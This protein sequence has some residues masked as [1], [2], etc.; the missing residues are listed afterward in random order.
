MPD[1]PAVQVTVY[2]PSNL[3]DQLEKDHSEVRGDLEEQYGPSAA[4]SYSLSQHV[5]GILNSYLKGR[6]RKSKR[7]PR[8]K[9]S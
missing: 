8:R 1:N 3:R 9:R 2:L 6:Q 5:A 7:K 4:R